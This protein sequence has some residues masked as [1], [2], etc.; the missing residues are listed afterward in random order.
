MIASTSKLPRST[1][2][3]DFGS[4]TLRSPFSGRRESLRLF[5][6]TPPAIPAIAAPPAS[7]G[8]FAFEASSA[9]LPPAFETEPF[10]N[11][12]FAA[13]DR[14]PARGLLWVLD[15]LL[16]RPDREDEPFREPELL[17]LPE[18]PL[19]LLDFVD[20]ERLRLDRLLEDRV[21]WA[22]VIASLGFRAS[23]AF[24]TGVC[25]TVYPAFR[26]FEPAPTR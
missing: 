23:C 21:V 11:V 16:D 12:L 15:R 26:G 19:A 1:F 4:E 10:D 17:E 5:N 18:E 20:L 6:A 9:T 24:R 22:M 25:G 13:V 7:K 8:V 14:L 2:F 3:S